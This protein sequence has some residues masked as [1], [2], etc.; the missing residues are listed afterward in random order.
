MVYGVSERVN[1]MDASGIRKMFE[2][3]S[4]IRDPINLSIGQPDFDAPSE[5]KEKAIEAIRENRNS[6]TPTSGILPLREAVVDKLKAQNGVDATVDNILITG[7]VSGAL[8]LVLPALLDEG[9]EVI[10]FDPYFVGYKQLVLLYGG[11]PVFVE[12][13][14]DFTINFDSLRNAI[15]NKTKVILINSPENPTGYVYSK[16]EIEELAGIA[17]ENEL[18]VVSDEIY[19]DFV[20]NGGHFSIASIYDKTVLVNGFSKSYAVTGWRVGYVMGPREVIDA[21]AKIQQFSFVCAPTPFQYGCL[22][23]FD[24]DVG[25]HVKEYRKRRDMIYEGLKDN[26]EINQCFGAFYFYVKY[27]YDGTRFVQ[28]CLD[29]GLL[30]VP[31]G[32]FSER[33]SH[34]R[35]SFVNSEEKL[36]EAVEILN[37]LV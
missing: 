10:I 13:N 25:E 17:R 28:D 34:F 33:N 20:Y 3:A 6:Y 32:S 18:Y 4:E 31:G 2:M 30:I 19:E 14:K 1:N 15:T 37:G 16:G 8:S 5:L 12:K 23:A 7:A 35:L 11:K 36:L 26:F 24:C 9:D 21:A 29:R 27:P 22:A